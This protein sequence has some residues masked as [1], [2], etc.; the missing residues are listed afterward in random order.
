M[1]VFK[2]LILGS[3]IIS[4][5]IIAISIFI[6]GI[7]FLLIA[8]SRSPFT[9]PAEADFKS[10]QIKSQITQEENIE[11]TSEHVEIGFTQVIRPLSR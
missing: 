3:Y 8:I 2:R 4:R 6:P 5:V 7:A 10:G 1:A 11:D 9:R